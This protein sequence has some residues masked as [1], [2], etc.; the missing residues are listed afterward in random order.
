M[1]K[2]TFDMSISLDGFITGPG[3]GVERLHE[4]LYDLASWRERRGGSSG[5]TGTDADVHQEAFA[6]TGAVLIG[7]RMFNRPV[8][9][10]RTRVIDSPGVTHPRFRVAR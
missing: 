7:R 10:E 2:L 6:T 8:E 5:T 9:L 4:W 3:D 1:G